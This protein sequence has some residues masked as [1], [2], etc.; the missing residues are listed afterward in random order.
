MAGLATEVME[1]A[2]RALGSHAAVGAAAPPAVPPAVPATPAAAATP[3]ASLGARVVGLLL[4]A[5]AVLLAILV[6]GKDSAFEPKQEFVLFAG[7]YV[8]AQAVERV[9]EFV[10]PPGEGSAQA[11]ADRV[12]VVGGLATVLGIALSLALGLYFLR[13]VQIQTPATWLDVLITGLVI[14]GGT[15]PLHDLITRIEKPA[16]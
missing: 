2:K 4:L 10:L 3:A 8:V 14:G 9:L 5:T 12:V 6:D 13:A 7:F 11:K 1:A 16:A 15:K